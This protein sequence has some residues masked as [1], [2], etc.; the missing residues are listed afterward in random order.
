[1]SP[2]RRLLPGIL[3]LAV[4][5]AFASTASAATRF[6]IKGAGFGHGVGMSQYGAYG[7]AQ[8]GKDYRFILGH[9]YQGTDMG[10]T[11]GQTVRVLLQS[12]K[13]R[14]VF[15]GATRAGNRALR[16]EK[17]YSVTRVDGGHLALRSPAGRRLGVFTTPLRVTGSPAVTLGGTAGNGVRDGNYRGA[18]EL[19]PGLFGGVV[20]V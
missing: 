7:F 3:A 9:Y 16:A 14:I 15:A 20:A 5:L 1:M 4:V 19:R 10:Q 17:T 18:L 2:M 8:H 6:F 11:S 12:G 13:S